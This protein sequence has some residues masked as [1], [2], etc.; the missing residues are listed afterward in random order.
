[1][2]LACR[3]FAWKEPIDTPCQSVRQGS[4]VVI[5]KV[6]TSD[7]PGAS[8]LHLNSEKQ[9]VDNNAFEGISSNRSSHS[10]NERQDINRRYSL[11]LTCC[12]SCTR[13]LDDAR[14]VHLDIDSA[15]RQGRE[16]QLIVQGFAAEQLRQERRS[17]IE[18]LQYL[19]HWTSA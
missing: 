19:W 7:E 1:M 18:K 16:L 10:T 5:D 13:P 17:F 6:E 4:L 8:H 15:D 2:Q 3:A 9:I 14:K 11:H 12:Y